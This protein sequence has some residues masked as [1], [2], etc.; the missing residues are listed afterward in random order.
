MS[1]KF[2]LMDLVQVEETTI[3]TIII[4]KIIFIFHPFFLFNIIGGLAVL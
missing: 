3:A 4:I 2:W 1:T